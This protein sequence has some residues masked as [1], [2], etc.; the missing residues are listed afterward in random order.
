MVAF[1]INRSQ[2]IAAKRKQGPIRKAE[3]VILGAGA[4]LSIL[5]LHSTG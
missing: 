1:V 5:N 3:E 4:G 2:W